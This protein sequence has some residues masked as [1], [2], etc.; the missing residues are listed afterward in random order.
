[1]P[2]SLAKAPLNL[3]V[4]NPVLKGIAQNKHLLPPGRESL[5]KPSFSKVARFLERPSLGQKGLTPNRHNC[6]KKTVNPS[7]QSPVQRERSPCT[8]LL[9]SAEGILDVK[10][11][12]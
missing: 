4:E 9:G 7:L 1:M 3:D 6:V 10:R 8:H 11:F 12:E 5:T 2:S